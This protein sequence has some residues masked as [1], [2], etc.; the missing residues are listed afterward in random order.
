MI[1]LE[2]LRTQ[3]DQKSV[4]SPILRSEDKQ[5]LPIVKNLRKFVDD[6]C[7]SPQII[8]AKNSPRPILFSNP[9]ARFNAASGF[10]NSE[11]AAWDFYEYH[12]G[13]LLD[14]DFSGLPDF[15][16]KYLAY[17]EILNRIKS[18]SAYCTYE[19]D[20]HLREKD[21]TD[22]N[23]SHNA[24]A[25]QLVADGIVPTRFMGRLLIVMIQNDQDKLTALRNEAVQK[26]RIQ[27]SK[28]VLVFTA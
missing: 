23:E 24:A 10:F 15:H 11:A 4:H 27:E 22:K 3:Q 18:R 25:D 12:K 21:D 28:Q 9:A 14:P 7:Q 2:A 20:Y 16:K 26:F 19:K 6:F 17:N 8:A 13:K 5:P 1:A